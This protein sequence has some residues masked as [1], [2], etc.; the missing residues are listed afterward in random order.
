MQRI[1]GVDKYTV[2]R[3]CRTRVYLWAACASREP[4]YDEFLV[5]DDYAFGGGFVRNVIQEAILAIEAEIEERQGLIS[6]LRKLNLAP[7]AVER[8]TPEEIQCHLGK[9]ESSQ[10]KRGLR[11]RPL[12]LSRLSAMRPPW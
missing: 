3:C 8:G 5:Y 4:G 7:A 10:S 6:K 12:L 9:E 2:P 1:V 11:T